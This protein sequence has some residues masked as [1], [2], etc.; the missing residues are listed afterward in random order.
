MHLISQHSL[1]EHDLQTPP[2]CPYF[3]PSLF[4]RNHANLHANFGCFKFLPQYKLI[5]GSR[6]LWAKP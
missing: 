2:A 4:T 6:F 5:T 3:V 1:R